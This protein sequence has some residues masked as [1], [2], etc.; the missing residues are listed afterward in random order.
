VNDSIDE[1]A[2]DRLV[3]CQICQGA[4]C[5]VVAGDVGEGSTLS[6]DERE[7]LIWITS[8]VA[9]R[10]VPFIGSVLDNGTDK[11]MALT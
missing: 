10:R 8:S 9:E 1:V 7:T 3:E 4:C 2:F 5:L 11:A 6:D